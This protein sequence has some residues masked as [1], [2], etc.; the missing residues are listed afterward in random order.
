[1]RVSGVAMTAKLTT[2][3]RTSPTAAWRKTFTL[4]VG[5]ATSC[6]DHIPANSGLAAHRRS[7]RSVHAGSPR[8]RPNDARNVATICGSSWSRLTNVLQQSG[9]TN[10]DHSRL[11]PQPSSLRTR[12]HIAAYVVFQAITS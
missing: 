3:R 4:V 10:D 7:I 8:W 2:D 5:T 12:G 1:M 9:I 11:R 6:T